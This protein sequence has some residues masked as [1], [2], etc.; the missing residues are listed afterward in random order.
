MT[1]R[2]SVDETVET[3]DPDTSGNETLEGAWAGTERPVK[4]EDFKNDP[5]VFTITGDPEDGTDIDQH[6][7]RY[8]ADRT[9]GDFDAHRQPQVDQ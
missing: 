2:D 9:E 4:R 1:Y 3:N 5:P 6:A 7:R 8:E